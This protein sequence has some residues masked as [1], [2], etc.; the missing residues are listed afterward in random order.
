M[1]EK[2]SYIH[3]LIKTADIVQMDGETIRSVWPP[4]TGFGF[5]YWSYMI[6]PFKPDN[7]LILGYG[8]GQ[9]AELTR[10]I[11]GNQVKIT[12]VDKERCDYKFIEY[13]IHIM[14]AYDFVKDCT[15]SAIKKR[16]DYI[17]IDLFDGGR[18]PAFV[19][20]PE[21]AGR[22]S[23]MAKRVVSMNLPVQDITTDFLDC[24]QSYGFKFLKH[25]SIEANRVIFW[26]V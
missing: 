25:D 19:Y 23:E 9:V 17:V 10:K 1:G 11:W 26:G 20:W 8:I 14:D 24:Y 3:A 22:L 13:K 21:F 12:G 18:V 4:E 2:M 5:G 6:P 7:M 15:G 16:Y